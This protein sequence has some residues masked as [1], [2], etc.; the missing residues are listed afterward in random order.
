MFKN[1]ISPGKL[2]PEHISKFPESGENDMEAVVFRLGQ[3]PELSVGFIKTQIAEPHP[4]VSN[5]V[6]LS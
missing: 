4:R 2:F 5:L 1:L 3:I 6:D